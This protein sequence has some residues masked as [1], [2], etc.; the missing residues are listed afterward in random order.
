MN[1]WTISAIALLIAYLLG[2]IPTGYCASKLLQ[3]YPASRQRQMRRSKT[4]IRT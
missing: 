4:R 1:P 3:R 2:A